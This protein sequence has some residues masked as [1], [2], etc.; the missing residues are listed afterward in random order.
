MAP[1][2]IGIRLRCRATF[3]DQAPICGRPFQDDHH[4]IPPYPPQ[5]LNTPLHCRS[6]LSSSFSTSSGAILRLLGT[7]EVLGVPEEEGDLLAVTVSEILL[8]Q[9]QDPYCRAMASEVGTV[10]CHFEVNRIRLLC[11]MVPVDATSQVA[12]LNSLRGRTV[13]LSHYLRPQ[14]HFGATRTC[15]TMRGD[16]YWP[17]MA[18]DIYQTVKDCRS[19]R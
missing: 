4:L 10:G 11:G 14:G 13:Y 3:R 19:L 9:G 17:H 2:I 18:A 12:I 8:A 6:G 1:P 15:E 5:V 16:Y 7:S